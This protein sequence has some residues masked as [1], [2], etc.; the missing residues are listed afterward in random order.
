MSPGLGYTD[1]TTYMW[2]GPGNQNNWTQQARQRGQATIHLRVAGTDAY[3][4]TKG[5][6][7]F[8]FEQTAAG[9]GGVFA[10]LI[11]DINN[12]YF[13]NQGDRYIIIT[14]VSFESIFDTVYAE[15]TQFVNQTCGAI[16]TALFNAFETGALVALGT[17]SNG[18]TIPL[19]NAPKGAKLN[20]LFDQLATTS[21]FT[22]FVDPSTL[23]LYFGD[24]ASVPAPFSLAYS[25]ILWDT[26]DW[27][28][29]N[30]DYRN[31]PGRQAELRRIRALE[32]I[33]HRIRTDHRHALA[34]GE[35]GN[36]RVGDAQHVQHCH[37]ACSAA[38]PRQMTR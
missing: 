13:G 1:R 16:V 30:A 24:P 19:F 12:V 2:K 25:D 37:R 18:A 17:I 14:A 22:W 11:Q 15:P 36:Q 8:L 38:S 27:K 23:L 28:L 5:S 32:G 20:D 34:A 29:K 6:P 9:Y 35:T 4:P 26:V 7:L 21:S 33:L 3:A 10:G 31:R